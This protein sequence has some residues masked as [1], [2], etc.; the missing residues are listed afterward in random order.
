MQL[1]L[2]LIEYGVQKK[3]L[4]GDGEDS[5]RDFMPE[6]PDNVVVFTEYAGDPI[7]VF[8]E[9]VHRSVQV[10]VRNKDAEQAY[11]K[12][13]QLVNIFKAPTESLRV[14]FTETLWGQIYIRQMPFKLSHDESDRVTYC[15]NLGITT[16]ILE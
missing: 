5:F 10:K 4:I 8:T 14:D 1:L 16:N 12:A 9:S 13:I 15:F 2:S 6:H 7:S 3:A 11:N